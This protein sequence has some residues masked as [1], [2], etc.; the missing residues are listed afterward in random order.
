MRSV[1]IVINERCPLRC[2]HC[3]V[4]FSDSYRGNS[5]RIAPATLTQIIE[6]LDRTIYGTVLFAGGEPSLDPG[7]VK[8]GVDACQT[9]GL[10]SSMITAPIWA[11]SEQTA[12]QLLDKLQGLHHMTLSFDLYH[13]EF[14]KFRHYELAAREALK[15][16][17][18]VLFHM[19]YS[20]E[21]ERDFLLTAIAPIRSL[22]DVSCM[23][24]VP[25]GNAA[26]QVEMEYITIE[27]LEDL[28]A[29][30]R[31]CLL[32]KTIVDSKLQVHG[33]CWSSLGERSPFSFDC[34]GKNPSSGFQKM[35]ADPVFQAVMKDGFLGSLSAE[36][37]RLVF[38]R[39][40][41]RR[42]VNE[43][44]L[45]VA[46]MKEGT[47]AIWRECGQAVPENAILAAAKA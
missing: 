34:S 44:D 42:F 29:V 18:R 43:C 31:G 10:V 15:R 13:L 7:L 17:I 2:R 23:R 24:A 27:T 6:S 35:E 46:I 30:P 22:V 19:T 4:G 41:G 25:V 33:C 1:T 38:D 5:Y 45:C 47:E 11:S 40:R 20:Q 16:D 37:R 3:S 9:A 26:T 39:I 28:E 21:G 8:I 12:G 36:G 32:G 14:L